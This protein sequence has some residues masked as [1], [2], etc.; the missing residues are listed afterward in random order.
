VKTPQR[1]PKTDHERRTTLLLAGVIALL[2]VA[3][4]IKAAIR[5]F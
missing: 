3:I 2:C 5:Y 1:D 4:A